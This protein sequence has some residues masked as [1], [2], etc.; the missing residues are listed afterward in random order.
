M[1]LDN[2]SYY[3]SQAEASRV[4]VTAGGRG[5]FRSA[6]SVYLGEDER[7]NG[8]GVKKS[9]RRRRRTLLVPSHVLVNSA[10]RCAPKRRASE[11]PSRD[12]ECRERR[13][14]ARR[15]C[16]CVCACVRALALARVAS[17]FFAL[18]VHHARTRAHVCYYLD[19]RPE[20][21]TRGE[22]HPSPPFPSSNV[23]SS[24]FIREFLQRRILDTANAEMRPSIRLRVRSLQFVL[25]IYWQ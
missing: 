24:R 11:S 8:G 6:A 14:R 4:P 23:T 25:C 7:R 10:R 17:Y 5:D 3:L 19:T 1:R 21:D 22:T 18:V 12:T 16:V 9:R 13:T 15:A 2:F 20:R